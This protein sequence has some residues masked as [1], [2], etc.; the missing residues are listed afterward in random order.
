MLDHSVHFFSFI[1][2]IRTSDQLGY[3]LTVSNGFL[4]GHDLLSTGNA[5]AVQVVTEQQQLELI[6][7]ASRA[8]FKGIHV[9]G[10]ETILVDTNGRE[11]P[12]TGSRYVKDALQKHRSNEWVLA[13]EG[14][15]I[16]NS[17]PQQVNPSNGL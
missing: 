2:L 12:P 6:I 7:A 14:K 11:G 5:V 17:K 15:P 1:K 3:P 8:G 10:I 4:P 9:Q 16:I 13:Q